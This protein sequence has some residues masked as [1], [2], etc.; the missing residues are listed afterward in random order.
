MDAN[1]QRF[2]MLAD[3]DDWRGEETQPAI[4]YDACCLRLRLRDRRPD[5]PPPADAAPLAEAAIQQIVREPSRAVDAFGTIAFWNPAERSVQASGAPGEDREPITLWTAP[6]DVAVADLAMGYDDVLYLALHRIQ[7][8]AVISSAI[9]MFD[10]RGRWQNPPVFEVE[11]TDFQADRLAAAPSSGVWVMDAQRGRFGRIHGLPLRDDLPPDF[12][13]TTFRPHPEN[14]DPPVFTLDRSSQP[15]RLDGPEEQRV[16]FASNADGQLALLT[17]HGLTLET[18][19]SWLHIRDPQLG[20]LPPKRLVGARNATSVAWLNSKTA[21]VFP[22]PVTVLGAT[23]QPREVLAYSPADKS[24]ALEPAGGFLP[25]FNLASGVF[26]KGVSL[27]PH[28]P[29]VGGGHAA[30]YPVSAKSFAAKGTAF[31]RVL[32]GRRE[33]MVWH[34]IFV[35]AVFPPACGAIVHLAASDKLEPPD[36]ENEWHPHLFGNL[37]EDPAT[38]PSASVHLRAVRGAWYPD[39]SEVPHRTGLLG[40]T[41]DPDRA[42][43]FGALIQRVGRRVRRLTGRFLHLRVQLFGP[44]H[45]TPEIAAVRIYGSR[46]AYR[47]EYLPELYREDQFGADADANGRATPSD[48][49]DRFLG[50]FESVLT[51][52][53]DRVAAAHALMDPRSTPDEAVEWLGSWIGV[54]FDP[55]FP[56]ERRRAWVVAAPRLFKTRGTYAG[57]QLALEIATGGGLTTSYV[58]DDE[59]GLSREVEYPT[60][61]HVTGGELTVIEDFRLRR[62]I[63]TILGADLSVKDDPLLPGL[64]VSANSYVGDTLFIGDKEQTELLA[65]FRNAF[66]AD[67]ATA[68]EE[69]ATVQAFYGKLAHRATVFVHDQ[70]ER[71]DFGLI[72]KVA[73]RQAPAHVA[74]RVVH[75]TYPL[76]VG[77]ASLVDVDTYL[78]PR[79][80]ASPV[81]LN[82]T[83]IGEGD[84]ILRQPSLDPRLS[85][86]WRA[87]PKPVAR[88]EGPKTAT[89]ADMITLEGKNSFAAASRKIARYRWVLKPN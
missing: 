4:E 51:P 35:E 83:R 1:R 64:I 17:W 60:G 74:V 61:G 36:D 89:R 26:M 41:P 59:M 77:L 8:G 10:P 67:P 63:A 3:Q 69:F 37:P 68:R 54:I 38:A 43:L 27:P 14:P 5:R 88:I 22:P 49:L 23:V 34:R 65:L 11:L 13:P 9:G 18:R 57:L 33:D 6:D 12:S 84:F 30:I 58:K 78:G 45:R 50:L 42:G 39:E 2:W 25:V 76:L 20:W 48:F 71:L 87:T 16:A 56:P 82:R 40:V 85:S 44:G 53:E 66:S 21:V 32:D 29:V 7:A 28:Y 75:A 31:G 19:E 79:P 86:F 15:S 81:Q 73:T 62:L 24:A 72:E 55:S 70:V 46:F 47:D 80:A 52:M